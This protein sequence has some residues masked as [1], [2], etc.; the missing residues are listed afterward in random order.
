MGGGCSLADSACWLLGVGGNEYWEWMW[1]AASGRWL[2]PLQSLRGLAWYYAAMVPLRKPRQPALA[3]C[4]S[5]GCR[6]GSS[7]ALVKRVRLAGLAPAAPQ[8]LW[9]CR[10]Q[11]WSS[12]CFWVCVGVGDVSPAGEL[13]CCSQIMW[14]FIVIMMLMVLRQSLCLGD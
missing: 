3:L 4:A 8:L 14:I 5:L 11:F 9:G 7:K 6:V 12:V 2:L 1:N 10:S 13:L